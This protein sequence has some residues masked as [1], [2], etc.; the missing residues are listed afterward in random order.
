MV[1]M[2]F[3]MDLKLVFPVNKINFRT[4]HFTCSLIKHRITNPHNIFLKFLSCK[5]LYRIIH[6]PSIIHMLINDLLLSKFIQTDHPGSVMQTKNNVLLPFNG[7]FDSF[8]KL[9][10]CFD[11][12][13]TRYIQVFL[14]VLT[15]TSC[16]FI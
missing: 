12:V 4:K 15:E 8:F 3:K 6:Q 2:P 11:T 7:V 1:P 5:F 13:L 9:F 10:L 14:Q 16:S